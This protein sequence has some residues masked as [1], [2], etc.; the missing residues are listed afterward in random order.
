MKILYITDYSQIAQASGGWISDYQNDLL[1]YGLTELFGDD[2]VDSTPIISL[3]KGNQSWIPKEQLWGGMTA[4]WLLDGDNRDRLNIEEKIK[5]KFYDVI[6]YGAWRRCKDYYELVSKTYNPKKV[7]LIDG[8]DDQE[9]HLGNHKNIYFKR[10]LSKKT[11]NVFPIG[12]AYPTNRFVDP[13]N[14]TKIKEY[15]MVIPGYKNTYIFNNEHDYY[16]D[17]QNSYYGVTMKKAG[18]DSL[19]HYEIIGNYCMPYFLNIKD[20]PKYTLDMWPKYMLKEGFDLADNFDENK[21]YQILNELFS[22]AKERLTTKYLAQNV[23]E[24]S[25]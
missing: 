4:F 15:G 17:Y 1:F 9:L 16:Q 5:D 18:W 6:I 12:F 19:R 20:C 11:K 2:V 25:I 13:V 24:K 8:N 14:I 10:E 7:I 22:Y 23:I 21:Y 3:Y